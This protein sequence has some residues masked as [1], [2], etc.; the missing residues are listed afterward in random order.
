MANKFTNF[1]SQAAN[2]SGNLRDYQH[3]ARLYVDNFFELA[4]KAGWLYYVAFNIND[5]VLLKPGLDS[6]WIRER[7]KKNIVGILV[8]SADLP[9]YTIKNEQLN[10]YN[11]KT[12]I[13]TGIT[14]SPVKLTLHDDMADVTTKL[15]KM[16]YNYYYADGNYGFSGGTTGNTSNNPAAYANN[17]LAEAGSTVYKYGLNND[18]KEQFFKSIDIY[19][20]NKHKFTSMSLI[21][22]IVSAWDHSKVDQTSQDLMESSMTVNYETVIYNTNNMPSRNLSF[23]DR[24]YY[25]V[26]SSPLSVAGAGSASLLGE[27][28]VLAGASDVFGDITGILS[29]EKDLTAVG[30]INTLFKANTLLKNAKAISR[31]GIIEEASGVLGKTLRTIQSTGDINVGVS[32][33]VNAATAPLKNSNI[34]IFKNTGDVITN[35]ITAIPRK[36]DG[37]G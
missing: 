9:R 14:Y 10:Q 2:A 34:A 25:D 18:Q 35:K 12:Y 36:L 32:Q 15:W 21:N 6:S 33:A 4:P 23:N 16:Y 3:A 28:G 27:G 13:Q 26:T 1:L 22:P 29:G 5:Q 30:A 11:R 19:L 17:K 7:Y 24:R 37:G 31:Q 8:K 20:L